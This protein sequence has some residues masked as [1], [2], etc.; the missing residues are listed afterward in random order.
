MSMP[1]ALSIWLKERQ[2]RSLDELAKLAEDYTLARKDKATFSPKKPW[3]STGVQ[4]ARTQ[5]TGKGRTA[6]KREDPC[7]ETRTR[8]N[9]AGDKQCFHCRQWGHLKGGGHGKINVAQK[10]SI[11]DINA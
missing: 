7:T 6:P 4:E 5:R 3:V 10:C 1:E 2:S 8:V 11:W 9:T